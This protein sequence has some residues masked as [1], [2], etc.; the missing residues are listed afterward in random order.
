MSWALL[1]CGAAVA[2]Y[3]L[4]LYPLLLLLWGLV[5]PRP[6]R[7]APVSATVSILIPAR[8]EERYLRDK[9]KSVFAQSYSRSLMRVIVISDGSTDGTAAAAREFPGVEVI[10]L[11]Q[12]GKCRALNAGMERADGELLL[13]TDARQLL[14][15]DCVATLLSCFDD[16]S[17]GVASGEV[18]IM[19]GATKEEESVRL[20]LRIE[21]WLRRQIS[22]VG[23]VAG[24]TGAI[25]AMRRSLARPLPPDLLVDDMYQPIATY[26]EGYRSILDGGAIAYD[27]PNSLAHE[28]RRKV[29]TLAGI[30]QIMILFPK[31]FNL[32]Y[33]ISF[34]FLSHKFLRLLLP[35]AFLAIAIGSFLIPSPWRELSLAVQAVFYSL[36]L[37]DTITPQWFP[38]KKITVLCR[39]FATLLAA[40]VAAVSV[41][42]R[43]SLALWSARR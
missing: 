40:S 5:R 2:V 10:E 25:Y 18:R 9:L 8:N 35:Y 14:H 19:K 27:Y 24:A 32:R 39:H 13:F 4:I 17:I 37:A 31:L 28:F 36:A 26:F 1:L 29:R 16:P 33:G 42:F 43:P 38:F 6:V 3:S 12:G 41:L 15:P 34:H 11:P 20:Y 7:R 21:E 23:S 30:Y 22:V